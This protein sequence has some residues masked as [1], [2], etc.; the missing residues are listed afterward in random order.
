MLA[1]RRKQIIE[2]A[3]V[4]VAA[5][6]VGGHYFLLSTPISAMFFYAVFGGMFV[7]F[8]ALAVKGRRFGHL[9]VAAG[10]VV[11]IIPAFNEKP[12]NLRACIE[13]L[14]TGTVVPDK[15]HVV[16]DGSEPP[17]V[18]YVHE[19]V[20]WHRTANQGKRHAQVHGLCGEE[21]DFLVTLDS[22]SVPSRRCLEH[23]LRAFSDPSVQAASA[24]VTALNRTSNWLARLIDFEMVF[25]ALLMRA[26]RSSMGAVAPT[27]GAFSIY[28]A[29][30]FFEN[31]EDYLESGTSGDD[32][33]LCHYA[34][35]RGDV[36]GVEE[37]VVATEVP[38]RLPQ[39]YKQRVRWFQSHFRYAGWELRR[40]AGCAFWLRCWS[41]MLVALWPVVFFGGS[42]VV[43]LT[44]PTLAWLPFAYWLALMYLATMR[45]A[46]A[47]AD[48]P[49]RTRWGLWL[50]LTPALVLMNLVIVRPA[51]YWAIPTARS[52]AWGTRATMIDQ[53][54][55][56]PLA[57]LRRSYLLSVGALAGAAAVSFFVA[58]ALGLALLVCE[59]PWLGRCFLARRFV[60]VVGR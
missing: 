44:R 35:L 53:E 54:R 19:R 24:V 56:R 8:F 37:A 14:L 23:C 60:A 18:P 45:Y 31:T 59:L 33:R 52:L 43:I 20:E 6:L 39:L 28:R 4:V 47:R 51:M 1:G 9:P 40:L 57:W 25:G 48:L 36:V 3:A 13:A 50:V 5:A 15:I 41:L 49:G 10:R 26:A 17:L 11:A 38:L 22:D 16:D 55:T 21:T 34:L 12:E 32:R 46:T 29:E 30:L 7:L 42:L 2:W 27:N 58:P